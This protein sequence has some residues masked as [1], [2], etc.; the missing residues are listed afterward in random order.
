MDKLW[1][2]KVVYMAG[3]VLTINERDLWLQG[4]HLTIFTANNKIK[5]FQQQCYDSSPLLKDFSDETNNDINKCN[6]LISYN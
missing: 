6:F 1:V 5:A 2:F 4:K 3:I